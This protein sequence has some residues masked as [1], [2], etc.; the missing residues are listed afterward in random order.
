[1]I[2]ADKQIITLPKGEV[3]PDS[4]MQETKGRVFTAYGEYIPFFCANCGEHKGWVP[5]DSTFMFYLCR[6]CEETNGKL[7]VGM[8]L[9]DEDYWELLKQ[10]QL[11]TYG[12]YLTQEE[13][14]KVVEEDASPLAALLKQGR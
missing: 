1:M 14:A 7:T 11:A 8:R 10:E 2:D 4:R 6:K 3:L 12:H 13:L 9:P 5:A